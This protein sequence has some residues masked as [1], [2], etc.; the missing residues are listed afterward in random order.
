MAWIY[1]QEL[2][3]SPSPLTNGCEWY[4]GY[5]LEWTELKDWAIQWFRSK[6]KSR[7]KD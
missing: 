7:L 2:A 3:E 5:P 1:F 6:Q 4:M